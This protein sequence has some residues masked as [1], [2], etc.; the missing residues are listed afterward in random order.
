MMSGGKGSTMAIPGIEKNIGTLLEK[1]ARRYGEQKA[2]HFDRENWGFSFSGLNARV[3]QFAN[4]L[5][6]EGIQKGDHVAVMLP[7]CPEF[8]VI[9]LALAKLGA[10]MV[11]LNTRYQ[12]VDLEYVLNDSDA[13]A[14][15]IHTQFIPT[16]QKARARTPAVKKFYRVGEGQEDAGS[17][18][19]DLADAASGQFAAIDLA[20]DDLMNIQYTSGTTG[21]PKGCMLTHEYWLT[22]GKCAAENLT[23]NDV[24]L[25]VTPFYY[26]DPQWELLM[27]LTAGATMVLTRKYSASNYMNLVNKYQVT[28]AWAT[29]AAWTLKQP[30]SVHDRSHRLK[31]VFVGAFPPHLHKTFEARFN[32]PAREVYGMTEIGVGTMVSL[33]DDHMT[34]SGSVGKPPDFRFTQIIDNHGNPVKQGEIGELLINGPGIFKGYY[35]KPEATARAFAGDWFRTG[36][37][38]RQDENGYFYIVGRIKDMIRRSADNISASEVE[39]VLTS[40]PKIISAAVVAVPDES[41]GEEVKA[42]ICPAPGETPATIPPE[43]VIA[44]CLERIAEFKVPRYIEYVD[45]FQRTGSGKIQ[46]H[47]L[48]DAKEDLTAGCYDRMDAK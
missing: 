46:K 16:Y 28:A 5:Q 36:D 44:F 9:W 11:P 41:R 2:L 13:M 38:F 20:P 3:N 15:V 45:E 34:G 10:V 32:V 22:I 17:L 18:L 14:L 4:A 47:V 30:E 7:N 8:P 1:S 6:A 39:H 42:Y 26:M 29:M 25:V 23:E 31:F 21:F 43:D 33:E 27:C 35:N 24:F 12:A 48:V 40:H 37:L 19:G